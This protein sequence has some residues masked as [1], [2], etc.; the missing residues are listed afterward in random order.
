MEDKSYFEPLVEEDLA[1]VGADGL[2]YSCTLT[3]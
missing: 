1:F 2:A 3:C